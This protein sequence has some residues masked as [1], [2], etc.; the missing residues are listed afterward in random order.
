MILDHFQI[1]TH[2][3][4]GQRPIHTTTSTSKLP[5]WPLS[6]RKP[7]RPPPRLQMKESSSL[8]RSES[9][10]PRPRRR[11][12]PRMRRRDAHPSDSIKEESLPTRHQRRHGPEAHRAEH[13]LLARRTQPDLAQTRRTVRAR[14]PSDA[15]RPSARRDRLAV[16]IW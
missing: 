3:T 11:T 13:R 5:Y 14:L 7:T 16:K 15:P 6:T 8:I 12:S 10:R 1:N 9:P 4:F 2:T